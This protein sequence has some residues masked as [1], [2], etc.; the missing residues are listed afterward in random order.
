[1]KIAAADAAG[2]VKTPTMRQILEVHHTAAACAT[3]HR[4]FEPMGLALENFDA[5]GAWRTLDE[6]H[7]SMRP[8]C[9]WTARS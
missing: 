5:T 2:N 4:S 9:S 7:P 3:C 6:G 8:A 1:L